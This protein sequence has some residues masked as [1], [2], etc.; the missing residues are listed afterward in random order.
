[1]EA[2]KRMY[3]FLNYDL[4]KGMGIFW[5]VM[6]IVN[7]F[8]GILALYFNSTV[9]LGPVIR[10]EFHI[11]FAGSNI[12]AVFIFFIIYCIEMY[13]E[14]FTL[15]IGFGGTRK[16]FYKNIIINNITTALIFGI[17][18]ILL[19][20]I[21]IFIVPRL[22]LQPFVEYGLFNLDKDSTIVS[23][24]L[25]SFVFLV[26]ISL[27]NLIGI[28]QYRFSYK[29]WIGFGLFIFVSQALTD[30]I[31]RL[32]GGIVDF[33]NFME[34]VKKIIVFP[35]GGGL[36]VVGTLLIFLSYLIGYILIRR[37]TIK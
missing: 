13:Y 23:I 32:F 37:A 10:D 3:R 14:N 5:L 15:A 21:D 30:F 2:N 31:G 6:I 33:D 36:L 18:Q 25:L 16:V 34:I 28:L 22:G 19:I 12:F 4:I 1:M 35:A 20:K 8:T 27:M 7:I 26:F 11:S 9:I 24:L 29:F 17:I